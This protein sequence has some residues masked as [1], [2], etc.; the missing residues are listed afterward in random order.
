MAKLSI[1]MAVVLTGLMLV[2]VS[3]VEPAFTQAGQADKDLKAKEIE[4]QDELVEE[5]KPD[6]E[7]KEAIKKTTLFEDFKGIADLKLTRPVV[8]F[9]YIT[10]DGTPATKKEVEKCN[11]LR[12]NVLSDEDFISAAED[13]AWF[14][15]DATKLSGPLK[16]KYRVTSAPAVVFFDCTGKRLYRLTNPRQKV[17]TLVKKMAS[18]VVKSEKA[19][20]KAEKK[21]GKKQGGREEKSLRKLAQ[22]LAELKA[23]VKPKGVTSAG[24][25]GEARTWDNPYA[26]E[27]DHYRVRTTYS[28]RAC[29]EIGYACE[30][31]YYH[32]RKLFGMAGW[33]KK[34]GKGLVDISKDRDENAKHSGNNWPGIYKNG[35][36]HTSYSRGAKMAN[37]LF[38]EATHM[39]LHRIGVSTKDNEFIHEGFAV[40]F[41]NALKWKGGDYKINFLVSRVF[42]MLI[43]KLE[44]GPIGLKECFSGQSRPSPGVEWGFLYYLY[45]AQGVNPARAWV[46]TIVNN[47]KDK[48]TPVLQAMKFQNLQQF[49]KDF[50]DFFLNLKKQRGKKGKKGPP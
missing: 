4:P 22:K 13:F 1:W 37:V 26:I 39:F 36:A 8:I 27:T 16:K 29:Y 10:D 43:Q 23:Q 33:T 14:K 46:K 17:K 32:Q 42:K 38:H 6:K 9:F 3:S 40:T 49:E 18:F 35:C 50:R 19:K 48:I 41:G 11:Q 44:S 2:T 45:T 12:E 15:V 34:E 47:E 5:G 7:I 28:L 25:E 24:P 21:N 31:L 20:D 30:V